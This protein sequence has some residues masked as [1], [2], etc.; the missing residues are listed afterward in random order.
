MIIKVISWNIL[1]I[2]FV[3][4]SYYP[5]LNINSLNNRPKRIKKIINKLLEENPDI[6]LLQEVMKNE[7]NYLKKYLMLNYYFSGL[8]NINWANYKSSSESGNVTLF[9]KSI[10]LSKFDFNEIVYNGSV[11]GSYIILKT[12]NDKENIHVFNIHLDDVAWQTRLVQINIIRPLVENLKYCIIGGDFNQEF[13]KTSKIYNIKDF[14]I[15]NT[16][17]ITYYIEKYMNID[18]ILSNG[19]ISKK[20]N[21]IIEEDQDKKILFNKYGSDHIPVIII[22]QK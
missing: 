17:N 14:I 21:I 20:E 18:N 22:L 11:F 9:K 6:I 1:A 5:T 13:N 12:K 2:E 10:F 16:K 19:F 4:K 3:K 15:H 8:T 7:Y